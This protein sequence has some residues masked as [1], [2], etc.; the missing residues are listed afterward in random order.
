MHSD[1]PGYERHHHYSH[2][3]SLL[4][5]LQLLEELLSEVLWVV[6]ELERGERRGLS[7][8]LLLSFLW[9]QTETNED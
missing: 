4:R 7:G 9:K 8:L 3:K 2:F 1:E 6:D 5:P